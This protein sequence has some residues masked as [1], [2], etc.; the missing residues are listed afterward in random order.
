MSDVA[1]GKAVFSNAIYTGI[2]TTTR[3]QY[4]EGGGEAGE[5]RKRRRG[6]GGERMGEWERKRVERGEGVKGEGGGWRGERLIYRKVCKSYPCTVLFLL[7]KS[8]RVVL[9]TD[10]GD[11]D[12]GA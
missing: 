10:D 12:D 2:H 3:Q 5:G 9:S 11:I 6:D 1:H 8:Y 4:R 7:Q